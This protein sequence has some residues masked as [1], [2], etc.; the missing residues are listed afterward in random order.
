MKAGALLC[1]ACCVEYVAVEFDL[2]VDGDILRNVKALRCPVCGEEVFT[3]EQHE[4][5]RKQIK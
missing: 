2:D 3:P 5:I 4:E 1:P